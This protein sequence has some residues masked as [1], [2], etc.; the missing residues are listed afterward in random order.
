MVLTDNAFV[1]EGRVATLPVVDG[2][3]CASVEE[4]V[5]LLAYVE[6]FGKVAGPP[7][8]ALVTG[9][10]LRCG[11]IASSCTPDDDN[12]L[13][14]GTGPRDMSVAVNTLIAAGGGDLAV[15]GGKVVAMV[16]L[17]VGGI[18]S[19]LPLAELRAPQAELDSTVAKLGCTLTNPFMFLGV[20][21]ITGIPYCGISDRGLVDA[22]T[23]QFV[24][25]VL[26][27]PRP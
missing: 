23:H 22:T 4:G 3:I 2:R 25:P 17:P 12:I 14:V 18:V 19:D 13:V 24:N 10:N 20:L 15:A 21:C 8:V 16:A 27:P 11:A 9:F 1:W 5:L 7:A 6:R 26:G